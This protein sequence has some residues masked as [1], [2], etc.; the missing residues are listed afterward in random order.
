[1]PNFSPENGIKIF[2]YNRDVL[3]LFQSI[4]R[5]LY[6]YL[7]ISHFFYVRVF[8]DGHY[9]LLS[10]DLRVVDFYINYMSLYK[11]AFFEKFYPINDE[12]SKKHLWFKNYPDILPS[13]DT[14]SSWNISHGLNVITKRKDDKSIE[15]L[16]FATDASNH[17]IYN[18]YLNN[19]NLLERF[20]YYFRTRAS[21]I[22]NS[23]STKNLAYS[24]F[25]HAEMKRI[26]VEGKIHDNELV[27]LFIQHTNLQKHKLVRK[28]GKE[29]VLS[30]REIDCLYQLTK[31]KT[32]KEIARFLD[33]S[34]RTVESHLNNTKTKL[35]SQSKQETIEYVSSE[36]R[37]FLE[38]APLMQPVKK[39]SI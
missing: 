29:V 39:A 17:K 16:V 22:I 7:P 20:S 25:Y 19:F 24:S 5:P 34:Y 36:L 27:S 38:S 21:S 18:F 14:L 1:M 32:V 26:E 31:C 28:D 30:E 10:H 9:F 15:K 13:L 8:R 4:C 3:D 37:S 23:P 2:D 11:S 12:G 33:I 6:S 35:A